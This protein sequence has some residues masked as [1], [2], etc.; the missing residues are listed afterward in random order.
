VLYD[1]F[2][3]NIILMG[4]VYLEEGYLEDI[5]YKID[6]L[7]DLQILNRKFCESLLETIT[8]ACKPLS[9]EEYRKSDKYLKRSFPND[10]NYNGRFDE[11]LN[12]ALNVSITSRVDKN[13]LNKVYNILN[14]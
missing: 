5:S 3:E 9:I 2:P 4:D 7:N 13:N 10:N 8:E 11:I 14:Y 6:E 1:S 12:Y